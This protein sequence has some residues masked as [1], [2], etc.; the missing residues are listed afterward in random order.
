[1]V[2]FKGCTK[3]INSH[4]LPFLK[5]YCQQL[6]NFRRFAM[7]ASVRKLNS[8]VSLKTLKRRWISYRAICV[9]ATFHIHIPRTY[10]LTMQP[11]FLLC[12]LRPVLDT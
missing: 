2:L 12:L 3:W 4:L 5:V 7:L 6:S 9:S 10:A 8:L 1:M 11:F